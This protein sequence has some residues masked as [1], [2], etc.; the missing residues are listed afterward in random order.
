MP[1]KTNTGLFEELIGTTS[2][3]R[4]AGV[5][6]E[7]GDRPDVQLDE[8]FG[9]LG[10]FWHPYGD[11][12]S[13]VSSIGLARDP[14]RSLIERITNA[15]DAILD[16]RY[17]PS[18]IPPR[19]ARL[20]AR[21]WFG[22]PVTGPDDGL[23]KW[24]F[25]DQG[26]DRRI[27]VILQSSD[28]ELAPT[29]D[30][31]DDGVGILPEDFPGTILSLQSGNKIR[32]SYLIGAFG[33]GGSSTLSFCD[34]ALIASRTKTSPRRLGFTLIRKLRLDE[35]W[36]EDAYAYL[37]IG[38]QKGP[39]QVP[40]VELDE[41]PIFPY[42]S[43]GALSL[44]S[45]AKGTLVRHY[46]YR[47]PSLAGNLGPAP[48]NLYHHL[49][50]FLLDPLLPFRLVDIRD[51]A[52]ARDE[53]VSGS[54][55]RLM[56]LVQ[57]A[58]PAV[59]EEERGSQIRHYRPMEYVVPYGMV[60]PCVG[61]EYWVVFNYRKGPTPRGDLLLRG[62]SNELYVQKAHPVAATLNG[63]T[64]GELTGRIL[65]QLGLGM[66]SRHL[67]VH[68][69]AT[70]VN[71]DVRLE[72][73][74]TAREGFKEGRVLD[75]LLKVLEQMLAEDKTLYE[76]EAELTRRLATREASTTKEEVKRQVTRLLLEAGFKAKEAGKAVAADSGDKVQVPPKRTGRPV[77]FNPLPTLAYP[78]VTY[79]QI[80]TPK[81]KMSIPLNDVQV[82]L[83]ETD[84]D[85]EYDRK[86][87]V[88]IRCEPGAL[89]LAA[90]SPL[91]GGR[92]RWRLR[93][94][95]N[96]AAGMSGRVIVTLT[97]PDGVQLVDST[98]Y[99]ILPAHEQKV[100]EE[101][102]LVP[103]FEIIP[104]DPYHNPDKWEM[105]WPSVPTTAD[106]ETLRS[107][108][109]KPVQSGDVVNV[110][111][112][113]IFGSLKDTLDRMQKDNASLTDL[114]RTNYEIWIGYH[115]ILQHNE[116]QRLPPD[117]DEEALES[118][119]ELDRVRVGKLQVKEAIQAAELSLRLLKEEKSE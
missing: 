65:Q 15:I 10:L 69:D 13:N 79:F 18:V 54:R 49:H 53:L 113:T 76:I 26:Y 66:V 9:E 92:I 119:Q 100:K 72:L 115:A 70:A 81:P 48:G 77:T 87:Q 82:V 96:A 16:E 42:P 112:S 14:G 83:A 1:E 111:Y 89:E 61:I 73:F 105:V 19:S 114:F 110:F 31:I 55:N 99:E 60:E 44:P 7:Y 91:R 4:V 102:G 29:I 74:S 40:I 39:V 106:E 6:A 97:K 86:G 118:I 108:A 68:V 41:K 20:A 11:N 104:I 36:K 8:R 5:L 71:K 57:E 78:D 52:R 94:A 67:V 107:V 30:V 98:D 3:R 63:Q 46:S 117:I 103:P 58:A 75:S 28:G 88:A 23:F 116:R 56:R 37:C 2:S 85:A 32:K 22:R 101:R 51:P 25:S 50:Y 84:A 59:A 24:R 90:K 109:Y 62:D 12:A 33:Q 43:V 35:T 95:I 80:V 27:H 38:R 21:Q 64:Q 34:Y 17:D 47:I 45:L 93:P